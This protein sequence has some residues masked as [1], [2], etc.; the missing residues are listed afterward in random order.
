M[1]QG[2]KLSRIS[3]ANTVGEVTRIHY[4]SKLFFWAGE[5]DHQPLSLPEDPDSILS[6]H[7]AAHGCP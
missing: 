3:A 5:R 6:N 7:T 2:K 1:Q 4:A